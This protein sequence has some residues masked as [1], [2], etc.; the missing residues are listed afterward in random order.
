MGQGDPPGIGD[1]VVGHLA[2]GA[3]G[4]GTES[5]QRLQMLRCGRDGPAQDLGAVAHA[6]LVAVQGDD[7]GKTAKIA[8][9]ADTFGSGSDQRRIRQGTLRSADGLRIE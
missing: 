9:G 1:A 8:E 2:G 4:D 5:T 6:Q 7:Q 3:E